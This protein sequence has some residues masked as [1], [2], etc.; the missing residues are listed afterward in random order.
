MGSLARRIVLL[1]VPLA[2]IQCS[3]YFI[4]KRQC[5]MNNLSPGLKSINSPL[6]KFCKFSKWARRHY[7]ISLIVYVFTS[8]RSWLTILLSFD[9]LAD[10]HLIDCFVLG[11]PILPGRTYKINSYVAQLASISFFTYR[12]ILS[13]LRPDQQFYGHEF[14]L[15]D[16]ETVLEAELRAKQW[17]NAASLHQGSGRSTRRESYNSKF[18]SHLDR[19]GTARGMAKLVA[20]PILYLKN[21][22]S[23][24][25]EA[26]S[27]ILRPCR[28]SQSWLLLNRLALL[29]ALNSLCV[30]AAW[31][32][33]MFFLVMPAILTDFGFELNYPVCVRWLRQRQRNYQTEAGGQNF[34]FIYRPGSQL[35]GEVPIDNLPI[36]LPYKQ[37]Q[38]VTL[39]SV[40]RYVFDL[41]INCFWYF[42]LM[43]LILSESFVIYLMSMDLIINARGI[44]KGLEQVIAQL[45]AKSKLMIPS[46]AELAP[47][48]LDR[49]RRC[50]SCTLSFGHLLPRPSKSRRP[51]SLLDVPDKHLLKEQ[52]ARLQATI[53]DHFRLVRGYNNHVSFYLMT[54]T[55]IWLVFTTNFSIWVASIKSH[56]AEVEFM[57]A[58]GV[59][60][61]ILLTVIASIAMS[62]C[63]NQRLYSLMANANALDDNYMGTKPQWTL[64][65][66]YYSPKPLYC[67][68]LLGS[69][70]ISWLFC[71]KVSLGEQFA[72]EGRARKD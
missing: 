63:C 65:M 68:S 70:E 16:Y 48:V 14:I 20:N 46:L 49:K 43:F 18:R 25:P 13:S 58:E 62:R 38:Q 67:F 69:I 34:T 36:L 19:Q 15:Y 50:D 9:L 7:K 66:L 12:F 41:S 1:F 23:N 53:I 37:P 30:F 39:Y 57:V 24:S 60:L 5:Q 47:P 45:Q 21:I 17:Q 32:L 61:V 27:Y 71:L 56:T 22:L 11:R 51:I 3:I 29:M 31:I 40:V 54:C 52:I 10:Y 42:E 26:D 59:T 35:A 64:A 72:R 44:E 28:T 6:R 55:I 2:T 8:V 33:I 4:L